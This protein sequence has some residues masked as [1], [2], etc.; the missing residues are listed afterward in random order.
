M[1]ILKA[2]LAPDVAGSEVSQSS[3]WGGEGRKNSSV[4]TGPQSSSWPELR[5][6]EAGVFASLLFG[7][8]AAACVRYYAHRRGR[9]ESV[10]RGLREAETRLSTAPSLPY[11]DSR[12]YIFLSYPVAMESMVFI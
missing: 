11:L 7:I 2:E 9:A 5:G 1:A 10:G 6:Q 8:C 3:A 12:S 4:L